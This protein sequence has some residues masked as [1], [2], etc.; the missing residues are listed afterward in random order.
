MINI[1]PNIRRFFYF[2]KYLF[3][4]AKCF[5]V[6]VSLSMKI[7]KIF[8]KL[9][10]KI[11]LLKSRNYLIQK[12]RIEYKNHKRMI[13]LSGLNVNEQ[14]KSVILERIGMGTR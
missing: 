7:E 14:E 10:S 2:K 13:E 3:R 8:V 11:L 9:Q 5:N 4:Y 12:Q 6:L 1:I